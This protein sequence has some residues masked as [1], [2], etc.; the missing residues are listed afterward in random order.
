MSGL[1][2]QKKS[3]L[4]VAFALPFGVGPKV[5]NPKTGRKRRAGNLR[6]R[7]NV[8][9]QLPD[10]RCMDASPRTSPKVEKQIALAM[11]MSPLNCACKN[12]I[13]K[14][15]WLRP[16]MARN[17]QVKI[18]PKNPFLGRIKQDPLFRKRAIVKQV[19]K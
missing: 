6:T 11:Y 19:W 18:P 15:N 17:L 5:T 12:L 8:V 9:F 1:P 4:L 14:P 7:L 16:N 3:F 10:A 13:L 2:L